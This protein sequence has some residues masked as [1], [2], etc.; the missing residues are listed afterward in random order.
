MKAIILVLITLMSFGSFATERVVELEKFFS[1]NAVG[2]YKVTLIKSDSYKVKIINNDENVLDKNIIIENSGG[3][4]NLKLKK[5]TYV[6]RKI[7]FI[8]YY[9]ELF[10]LKAI[11]GAYIVVK[12][13][14]SSESI[15]IEVNS[16]AH[17]VIGVNSK[18]CDFSIRNGGTIDVKGITESAKCYV[19][20]GGNILAFN[21][22]T[23]SANA[24][25]L[26]GGEI[27]LHV[28]K[29]VVAV[30]KSG[31]VIKYKGKPDNVS[32]Q[33]K[34]GGQIIKLEK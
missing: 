21:L 19:S 11:R 26:F 18:S 4:L 5:D 24:E 16:G 27:L 8:V 7:E 12:E 17:I 14:V 15:K 34:I 10:N 22:V 30:V 32:D 33:I 23:K 25:V 2:N 6:E 13:E 29:S 28:T 3:V 20:K 1:V 9:K 31:G